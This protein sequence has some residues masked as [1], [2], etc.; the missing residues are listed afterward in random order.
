MISV[1]NLS[2]TFRVHQKEAGLGGSLRALVRRKWTDKHALMNVDLTVHPGEIIGLIGAN[3]AGKTTL[4][5]ILA[6]IIHPS[7]G[8][9]KVLGFEPWQ[10]ENSYRSQI[11]LIMGQKNQLWWDLPAS[12]CFLLLKEIYRIPDEVFKK[13]LTRLV[14][15][16]QVGTL[17]TTQVRRLSLGERMKMEIIAAMLHGPKVIFLDEP[18]IGL[19]LSAQRVIR[20]FILDYSKEYKPIIVLTSHYMADIEHLCER[21]AVIQAGKFVYDGSITGIVERF[22]AH[23]EVSFE[24]LEM[25]DALIAKFRERLGPM[26]HLVQ[27]DRQGLTIRVD[28]NSVGFLVSEV[29]KMSP[30]SD[31]KIKEEDIA[32]VVEKVMNQGP[33]LNMDGVQ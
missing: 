14:D 3:G 2:K 33:S 22:R 11:G 7:A 13:N 10:R 9:V 29:L 4:M 26:G 20:E 21:I 19:D 31:V 6:G 28:P 27:C 24:I 32:S 15:A 25:T 17:L 18:T 23:K 30:V 1:K 5:K 12:D 16:L 8:E